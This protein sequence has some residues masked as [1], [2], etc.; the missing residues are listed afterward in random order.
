MEKANGRLAI[1][2]FYVILA[3]AA[4]QRFT[5]RGAVASAESS[6]FVLPLANVSLIGPNAAKCTPLSLL[7]SR[8]G[9][10]EFL[11]AG[12]APKSLSMIV[13]ARQYIPRTLTL[14]KFDFLHVAL[15]PRPI[16]GFPGKLWRFDGWAVEAETGDVPGTN[17]S[18]LSHPSAFRTP[19]GRI[20]LISTAGSTT[21][22]KPGWTQ[23]YWQSEDGVRAVACKGPLI[24]ESHP[25]V[26]G[27][28]MSARLIYAD[29]R[30]FMVTGIEKPSQHRMVT[31]LENKNI[32][33]PSHSEDWLGLGVVKVDF[34][35]APTSAHEDYRLH[36]L[37]GDQ[38][39][40]CNGQPRKYWLLIIPDDVPGVPG[41]A[42][43]RMAFASES[44][45]GP[46]TWCDWAVSP[47]N[48]ACDAFPGDL[49]PGLHSMFF[50][51]SY[52]SLYKGGMSGPLM[53][54]MLPEKIVEPAPRGEWDDLG[55]VAL[56]FLL[57]DRFSKNRARLYH[58]SYSTVGSN[59][60]ATK[61]DFGYKLAIGMYS[62]EWED[63]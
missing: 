42:C 27:V 31:I 7:T 54:D 52:G 49:I 25:G 47:N 20:F 12:G 26:E 57:P 60:N 6:T 55:Q 36:I 2:V 37:E 24:S 28:S 43:G 17:I 8:L 10:F 59:P 30:L 50:A 15:V 4:S 9:T 21:G 13:W 40:T 51:E 35:G 23:G 32:E 3:G 22:Q 48:T 56:T 46:Y 63:A 61:V 33:D 29:D 41:R 14:S 44:L 1:L 5:I 19:S 39:Y 18:F 45:L 11:C 16:P 34:T 53:F 58:A 62:F 38:R